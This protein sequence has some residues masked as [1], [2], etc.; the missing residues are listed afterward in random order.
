MVIADTQKQIKVFLEYFNERTQQPGIESLWAFDLGD[1]QAKLDNIPFLAGNYACEDIV[2]YEAR[3]GMNVVTEL[4][5]PS[6]HSCI[7][8][9][10][11]D[12]DDKEPYR[13]KLR[14]LGCES[15]G[16]HIPQ[17]IS[18]DLP[19]GVPY[20]AVIKPMLLADEEADI[21]SFREACLGQ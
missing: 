4:I 16:S 8:I 9:V 17:L 14:D 10:F 21:L 5:E 2:R 12:V 1:G 3:D 6:G 7:Q 13:R 18:V 11:F 15:E 19:P 20:E